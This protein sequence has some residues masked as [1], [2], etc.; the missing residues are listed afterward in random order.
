MWKEKTPYLY[1]NGTKQFGSLT[2]SYLRTH[3]KQWVIN[4]EIWNWF[5]IPKLTQSKKFISSSD[6]M[7]KFL[8]HLN[9]RD[10]GIVTALCTEHNT[11]G[12]HLQNM[13]KVVS[14]FLILLRTHRNSGPHSS[15]TGVL[16]IGLYQN[17]KSLKDPKF[18][19]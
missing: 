7:A 13:D 17:Y 2:K 10:L 8:L 18:L 5:S 6:T 9:K 14:W 15:G 1:T 19:Q 4:K 12:Y 3:F 11:L 16:K